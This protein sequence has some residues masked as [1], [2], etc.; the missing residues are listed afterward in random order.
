MLSLLDL[1]Q[2]MGDDGDVEGRVYSDWVC[3][4]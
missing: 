3:C 4:Q 2:L 1:Y